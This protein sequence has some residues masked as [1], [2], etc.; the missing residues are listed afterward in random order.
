[1]QIYFR[2]QTHLHTS[3]FRFPAHYRSIEW[4]STQILMRKLVARDM[5]PKVRWKKR[6]SS[7]FIGFTWDFHLNWHCPKCEILSLRALGANWFFDSR[8]PCTA[9]YFVFLHFMGRLSKLARQILIRK[10]E[11]TKMWKRK[12]W[13]IWIFFNFSTKN[14]FS[15]FSK[16]IFFLMKKKIHSDFFVILNLYLYWRK[17]SS[18]APRKHI[19]LAH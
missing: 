6:K 18:R 17:E 3:I 11:R 4:A 13:K 5:A 7:N 9:R 2:L 8:R 15:R 1:M 19:A 16:S 14:V 12:I 10:P